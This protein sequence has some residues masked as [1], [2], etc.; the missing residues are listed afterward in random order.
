MYLKQELIE[1]HIQ[2]EQGMSLRITLNPKSD[3]FFFQEIYANG[4]ESDDILV[5][6]RDHSTDLINILR[7]MEQY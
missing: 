4:E 5:I 1:Y 2:L 3:K 7:D 6:S